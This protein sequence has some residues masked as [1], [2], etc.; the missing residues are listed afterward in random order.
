MTATTTTEKPIRQIK[1]NGF[2]GSEPAPDDNDAYFVWKVV[3]FHNSA[4]PL[5]LEEEQAWTTYAGAET[6]AE[7]AWQALSTTSTGDWAAAHHR[8]VVAEHALD[9]TARAWSSAAA[10]MERHWEENNWGD[11]SIDTYDQIVR[12]LDVRCLLSSNRGRSHYG[13][14]L[15]LERRRR[16][17]ETLTAKTLQRLS[18]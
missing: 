17:R 4:V 11:R 14:Y 18:A 15:D 8:W 2:T 5:A 9:T 13:L 12:Q 3:R 16:E 10:E 1:A 6:A 7:Q